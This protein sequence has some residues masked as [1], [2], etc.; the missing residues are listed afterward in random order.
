MVHNKN[1]LFPE[2][3]PDEICRKTIAVATWRTQ[4]KAL[5]HA[6][7]A[8]I[9]TEKEPSTVERIKRSKYHAMKTYEI[10]FN[11]HADLE[12]Q[13]KALKR[14]QPQVSLDEAQLNRARSQAMRMNNEKRS[15]KRITVTIDCS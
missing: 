2:P 10:S 14:D 9:T 1:N 6:N 3:D 12:K 5:L 4:A 15:G 13:I 8:E 7:Q 11:S